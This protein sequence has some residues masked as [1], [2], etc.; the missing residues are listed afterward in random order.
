MK[1]NVQAAS[2]WATSIEDRPGGLVEKLAPLVAAG[3]NLEV[4]I[5]RRTPDQP[6][7]GVVFLTP[8]QGAKQLKAAKAAGYLTTEA[9]HSVR[10]EGPDQPGLA[11][12]MVQA[13]ADAGLNV[14]G[15][16]AT[17]IG[18]RFVAY[19]ALDDIDDAAKAIRVLRRL[20]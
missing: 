12:K 7:Q 8:L 10:I 20:K 6:G 16:S 11:L 19:L 5:G 13:L 18:R 1:L 4:I 3:A 17:A 15:F 14:R 9:L 2:V